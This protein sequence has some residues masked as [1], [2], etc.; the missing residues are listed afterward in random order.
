M[1]T[2]EAYQ[3]KF[4]AKLK[5]ADAQI[6]KL[7]AQAES[8]QA[9]AKLQYKEQVKALRAKRD[10]IG[11]S[12]MKMNQKSADATKEIMSGVENAWSE[13]ATSLQ[14]AQAKFK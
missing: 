11:Q 4:E 5:E 7:A 10:E 13:F 2:Q 8:A 6:D 14:S 9:D 12:V 1:T 3:Q